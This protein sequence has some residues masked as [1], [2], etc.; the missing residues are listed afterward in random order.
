MARACRRASARETRVVDEQRL[1]E[2]V[3]D[4]QVGIQRRHRIL[5]DHRD[6]FAPDR[7]RLGRRAAQEVDAVEDGRAALDAAG[8][9]RDEAHDRVARHGFAGAGFADDPE[10]LAAF[11]GEADAVDR[12]IDAVASVE[13]GAEVGDGEER[14]EEEGGGLMTND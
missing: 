5:E 1:D 10:R 4:P 7:P 2:L 14:H 6:P 8:G 9:L 3:G 12:A 11:E 13:T